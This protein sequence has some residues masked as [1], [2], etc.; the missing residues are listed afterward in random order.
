M[1]VLKITF[2]QYCSVKAQLINE[3]RKGLLVQNWED[4]VAIA[5]CF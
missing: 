2:G 5:C 1:K 3:V 4:D